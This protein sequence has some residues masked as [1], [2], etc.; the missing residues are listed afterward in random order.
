M[1]LI[2]LRKCLI[3]SEAVRLELQSTLMI[4]ISRNLLFHVNRWEQVIYGLQAMLPAMREL[5]RI[6]SRRLIFRLW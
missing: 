2:L 1:T 6:L 4:P 3:D 5:L